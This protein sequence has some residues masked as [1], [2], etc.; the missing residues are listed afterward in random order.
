MNRALVAVF[1][2][3]WATMGF[4]ATEDCRA[5]SGYEQGLCWYSS[6]EWER[7]ER[8]FVEVIDDDHAAPETLKAMYFLGRTKMMQGEWEEASQLWIRLFRLSP[9][10]YREWNGDYL[11]GECRRRSGR[12]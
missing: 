11:L 3:S 7:A 2:C 8:E 12:G 5:G 4:S 6:E 10:F 1:L 9:A